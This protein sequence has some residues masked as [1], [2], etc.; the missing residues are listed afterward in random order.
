MGP[1]KQGEFDFDTMQV[2]MQ[3]AKKFNSYPINRTSA[4]TPRAQPNDPLKPLPSDAEHVR[5]YWE[6]GEALPDNID[7]EYALWVN[8][9][10][11]N[12]SKFKIIKLSNK[13]EVDFSKKR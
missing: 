5:W 7:H 6:S 3:E 1:S 9:Q 4:E 11:F 13:R 12:A 2:H 10:T 8:F